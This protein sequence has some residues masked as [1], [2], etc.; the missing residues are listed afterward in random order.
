M[1]FCV[2]DPN[3][4]HVMLIFNPLLSY[5]RQVLDRLPIKWE[6]VFYEIFRSGASI[7]EYLTAGD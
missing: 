6:K 2:L 5:L 1:S 4:S 3:Q 7:Y